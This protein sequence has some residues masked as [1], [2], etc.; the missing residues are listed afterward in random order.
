[1]DLPVSTL[2]RRT[3]SAPVMSWLTAPDNRRATWLEI[4]PAGREVLSDLAGA[5]VE[6]LERVAEAV[7]PDEREALL[8]G[9]E[10]FARAYGSLGEGGDEESSGT[11]G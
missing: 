2:V 10:G 4:T 6:A 1:M 5:R 8:L 7:S 11:A 3:F 9:A